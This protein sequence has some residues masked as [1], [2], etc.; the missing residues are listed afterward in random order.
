[1]SLIKVNELASLDG[2]G[3][4]RVNA[5]TGIKIPASAEVS[6]EGSFRDSTGSVGLSNQ[7]LV[8]NGSEVVWQSLPQ[9]I[10]VTSDVTFN[11]VT[12][13]GDITTVSYTHLTLPTN[14]EV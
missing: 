7:Y 14:R 12:V 10:N 4:P 9:D 8:S 3:D 1:M 6:L 5:S 2:A 11:N 13:S